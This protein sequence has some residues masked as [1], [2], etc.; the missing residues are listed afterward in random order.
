MSDLLS[1]IDSAFD[2]ILH[3]S[4]QAGLLAAIVFLVC[5]ALRNR[6]PARWKAAL[7]LVVLA[8]F[9]LPV[10]PPSPT[11]LF[12]LAGTSSAPFNS[13]IRVIDWSGRPSL[14]PGAPLESDWQQQPSRSLAEPAK[15]AES[16]GRIPPSNLTWQTAS[17]RV[18]SLVWLIVAL[19]L[20]LRLAISQ[21]RLHGLLRSCD[22][23]ADPALESLLKK[24]CAELRLARCVPL[25]L[26]PKPMSPSVV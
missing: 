20:L 14:D 4:W 13:S 17:W 1:G 9:V 15:L 25:L 12:N 24:C 5:G 7:W 8:R 6:L 21:I 18:A 22:D 2:L 23:K 26:A 19:A 16:P 11:S 3:A 10:V